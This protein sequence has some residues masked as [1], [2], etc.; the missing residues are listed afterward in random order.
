MW[1]R[2]SAWGIDV[3]GGSL[4]AVRIDRGGG[5]YRVLEAVDLP[6][7]EAGQGVMKPTA[8]LPEGAEA[9]LTRFLEEHRERLQDPVFVAVHS[10][11]SKQGQIQVPDLGPERLPEFLEYEVEQLVDGEPDW[12]VRFGEGKQLRKRSGAITFYAQKKPYVDAFVADLQR[13]EL[14]LDGLVPEGMALARYLQLEWGGQDRRLAIQVQRARTDFVFM[15]PTRLRFRS[16]PIGVG[17]LTGFAAGSRTPPQQE[18]VGLVRRLLN[19]LSRAELQFFGGRGNFSAERVLLLGEGA[20]LPTLLNA[21]SKQMGVEVAV[22]HSPRRLVLGDSL[23]HGVALDVAQMGT[24]IGLALGALNRKGEPLSLIPPPT[25]RRARR[26]RPILVWA[27]IAATLSLLALRVQAWTEVHTLREYLASSDHTED[28]VRLEKLRSTRDTG[29]DATRRRVDLLWKAT[30]LRRQSSYPRRMLSVVADPSTY[31]RL[32]DF[33][34]E[35]GREVDQ[36]R[37]LIDVP[38]FVP[39]LE[40]PLPVVEEWARR[41][42]P[43]DVAEVSAKSETDNGWLIEIRGTTP[44]GRS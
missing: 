31:F 34:V 14:P 33:Q 41:K 38:K 20:S 43:M 12:L 21:L 44:D 32:A 19:E 22:L 23:S 18:V 4:K 11:A 39:G 6:Y 1:I 13:L 42:L 25:K 8:R 24:A 35:G 16:I 17:G 29:N 30:A 26:R 3:T 5:R 27:A 7:T 36:V 2:R 40:D 9:L 10:Y 28:W 15:T 37:L